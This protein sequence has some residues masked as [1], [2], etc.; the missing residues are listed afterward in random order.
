VPPPATAALDLEREL[1]LSAEILDTLAALVVVLDAE[2]RI[3][4]FNRACQELSGYALAEAVGRRVLDLLIPP[5]EREAVQGVFARLRSG[6]PASR[7]EN[8]WLTRDGERRRIAWSNRALRGSGGAVEL[9]IG[10]GI[11][12]TEERR[13]ERELRERNERLHGIVDSAVEAILTIDEKGEIQL[14]NRAAT[15]VFGWSESELVGMNVR[16]LMT[17]PHRERHDGYLARY[18]ATGEARII[19]IGREVTALRKDGTPFPVELSVSESHL[20]ARRLFTGIVRDLSERR[21]AEEALR[22]SQRRTRAAEELASI[23]NL[24]AGLAHEVGSPINVILGYA[25]MIERSTPDPE[26]AERVRIIAEQVHRVSRLIQALLDMAR[27]HPPQRVPVELCKVADEA[28]AFLEQKLAR[29]GIA[30]ERRFEPVPALCADPEKL[31]QLFLNLFLNAADAMPEGG[32]LRV[33][34]APLGAD[35]VELR[36]AD[37]GVGMDAQTCQ[38]IFEPFFSTKARGAGNGLGLAVSRGIVTD[39]GGH[40]E[41]ESQPGRGSEFRIALPL[42]PPPRPAEAA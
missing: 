37:T 28:L 14:A 40:I 15:R 11:D 20:G 4:R 33:A 10:T 5:D 31:Q 39:H 34:I 24:A 9:V 29:L 32:R 30:V 26:T 3:V 13:A 21:R 12:V 25:K 16:E 17:P 18:L 35:E 2:G 1:R 19:G 38:R 36:V 7:F 6:G 22:E 8:D 23:G 41:V 42:A 27:P